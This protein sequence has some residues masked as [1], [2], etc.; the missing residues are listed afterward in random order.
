VQ[1]LSYGF[2]LKIYF[3]LVSDLS[4]EETDL[5]IIELL[6]VPVDGI[7][8]N[9]LEEE[10]LGGFES[11]RMKKGFI[12]G[13]GIYATD[14]RIIGVKSRKAFAKV[15][16]GQLLGGVVGAV[17]GLKLSKDDSVKLIHELEG[18]KDFEVPKENVSRLEL[19][20]PTHWR[21]GHIVIVPRSGDPVKILI[22]QKKDFEEIAD[23]MDLFCREAVTL[24]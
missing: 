12:L 5:D 8:G 4:K 11:G 19:K 3:A 18:R 20:K 6:A 16:A 15:L 23:L 1:K 14:R 22:G 9:S 10:Y 17:V 2:L 7:E 24:I 21:R 13:Y